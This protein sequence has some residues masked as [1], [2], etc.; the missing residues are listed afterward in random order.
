[1]EKFFRRNWFQT[2]IGPLVNSA[3]FQA[4]DFLV[5]VFDEAAQTSTTNGGGHVAAVRQSSEQQPDRLGNV[6]P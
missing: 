5:I 1:V 3:T 4:G 2:H 6:T